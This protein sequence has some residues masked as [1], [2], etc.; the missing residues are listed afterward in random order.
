ML[1]TS[2]VPGRDSR[3]EMDKGW[4]TSISS[5]TS[6]LA[7]PPCRFLPHITLTGRE[8]GKRWLGGGQVSQPMVSAIST[9]SGDLTED[10][11]QHLQEANGN[12][13][14]QSA[15]AAVTNTIGC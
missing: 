2:H 9:H 1:Q 7:A 12:Q 10:S 8:P 6:F 13:T 15:W 14:S 5:G 11:D 3:R 4:A